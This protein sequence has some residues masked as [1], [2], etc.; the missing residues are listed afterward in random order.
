VPSVPVLTSAA[1]S[2]PSRALVNGREQGVVSVA[3]RGLLYGDGLF[4]TIAVR[5]G[6]PC[7]WSAHLARLNR[8]ADRLRIPRVDPA[9]LRSEADTL[10][11]GFD[12]GVLRVTLTRGQGGRGYRPPAMPT[13]TRIL[14]LYPNPL[15]PNPPYPNPLGPD[16][17]ST[18]GVALTHCRTR[19]GD[20]PLLAGIKH[21]N[22]LEQVL[23][24][25]EWDDPDIID[26]LM[27][28]GRGC[29]ICGTMTNLFVVQDSGLSTPELGRCGVAGTV[30][31]LVFERAAALGIPLVERDIPI[32][33]LT[34]A[35]G[36]LVTN[37]LLG[38]LPV[39]RLGTR[40][41]D[42]D[43]APTRL[44]EQVQQAVFE[45]ETQT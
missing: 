21:L 37:S 26:G 45:P 9:L 13:P 24:R 40:R 36:L 2:P 14:A 28:D 22:R 32:S 33:D 16:E 42:P 1:A 15:C 39:A 20:N 38:L 19:L 6:A 8:G 43:A 12:H 41:Y 7:R 31:E 4:E 11:A 30:R 10:L 27:T 17:T 35:K 3:D 5:R 23:A 18:R 34:R 25:A 44:V 29:V